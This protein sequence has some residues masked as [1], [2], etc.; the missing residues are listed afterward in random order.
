MGVR[1]YG[2]IIKLKKIAKGH[3]NSTARLEALKHL[4]NMAKT[5]KDGVDADLR[6]LAVRRSVR[7]PDPKNRGIAQALVASIDRHRPD[8]VPG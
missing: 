2:L 6:S 1:K 5:H 4:R 3:K 8:L 7:D